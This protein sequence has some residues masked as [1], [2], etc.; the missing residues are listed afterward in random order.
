VKNRRWISPAEAN[1]LGKLD[2]GAIEAVKKEAW[3]QATDPDELHDT[4]LISGFITTQ[5]GKENNWTSYFNDLII[6]GRATVLQI[7]KKNSLW[8]AT[9]RVP[10]ITTV[11]PDKKLIHQVKI[12]ER[13]LN[14]TDHDPLTE[15]VRGRLEIMGPVTAAQLSDLM[16]ISIN[17][18]NIALYRLENEGFVFRG[19]FT[20]TEELEWCERRLLARIHSY[21]IRKLRSEIQPVSAADFMR[22]LFVWHQAEP[23]N[24]PEGPDALQMALTKLEGFEAPAAAWESDILP[25]RVADYDYLWLDVLC[26]SGKISWGRFRCSSSVSPVKSTPITFVNRN[27]LEA[28]EQDGADEVVPNLSAEA[29]KV[30]EV[31]KQ[32]G[33]SFFDDIVRRT[34]LFAPQVENALGKLISTSMITSDS[35][36]GLRALLIPDKYK[37]NQGKKRDPGAFTM[38]SAGRWSLLE[39]YQDHE[40]G[41]K[42]IETIAWA[43]LRR[44]GVVFRK[45]AERENLA[46]AWRDMVRQFRRMEARGQIRGGRF[47]EGVWGEQFALPEAITELRNSKKRSVKDIL[48]SISAADPL[49]LTGILTPGNRIA[50]FTGNRI[51]Y[52]D[53]IPAA[54][55]ESK[56]IRF[57]T[58]PTPEERWKLQN[59]L[60]LR[61]ISPKLR[62]YLGKGVQ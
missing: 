30:L 31:L 54:V 53:G 39:N 48:V 45:L 9:E 33:A 29:V 7:N 18:I 62:K 16:S 20:G 27:N 22:F 52:K 6:E 38:S 58:H 47:V 51:L 26:I 15:L 40:D 10:F 60:V 5:E 3:P 13:Y 42:S 50:A 25:L 46:P 28:W 12:P 32:N 59:A 43:L 14:K 36:T 34:K 19:Q 1:D 44:Y 55:V 2:P 4:L 49:N 23:G 24:Q 35:F 56:E 17:D 11:Y 41:Q 57:L 37:T 61:N 8:I 21:T